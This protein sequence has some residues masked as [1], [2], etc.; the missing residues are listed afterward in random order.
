MFK[1]AV[2][3]A[4]N[5]RLYWQSLTTCDQSSETVYDFRASAKQEVNMPTRFVDV[6]SCLVIASL[7]VGAEVVT[8]IA[9]HDEDY[10]RH[11]EGS[12]I[13]LPDGRILLAWSRFAGAAGGD[14]GKATIV[15]AESTDGGKLGHRPG[16]FRLAKP[17]STSCRP[18][19]PH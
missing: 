11:S 1:N 12:A 9:L 7:A 8:P 4:Y 18:P 17:A 2:R 5:E 19:C 14:D 15:I 3:L 13:E 6:L 10:Y 16:N